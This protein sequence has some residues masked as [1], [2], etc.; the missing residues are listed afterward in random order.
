MTDTNRELLVPPEPPP[1]L[2]Q[3]PSF[4][5]MTSTKGTEEGCKANFV[6]Y[7]LGD[8]GPVTVFFSYKW[9]NLYDTGQSKI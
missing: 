2:P 7:G 8:M 9:E 4:L 3:S 5:Q 1:S 6:T